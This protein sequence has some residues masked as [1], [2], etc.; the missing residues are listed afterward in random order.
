MRLAGDSFDIYGTTSD[1]AL[2]YASASNYSLS[3]SG[4]PFNVGQILVCSASTNLQGIWETATNETTVYLSIRLKWASGSSDATKNLAVTLQD[5]SNN[6]VTVMWL[7][8]GSIS[9]RS[10]GITGTLLGASPYS[11]QFLLNTWDSWQIAFVINSS[12]GSVEVRKDGSNSD[13]FAAITN[14]NTQ[15]GSGNSTVSG[16]T[17]TAN[18][19]NWQIDDLWFNSASGA[20]PTSWPGD[21]RFK[22]MVVSSGTQSQF[23]PSPTQFRFGETTTSNT[24]SISLNTLVTTQAF[25]ANASGTVSNIVLSLNSG[26]TGNAVM[27]LYD[28]TGSGGSPGALLAS[29]NA[30]SNPV[31]GN[32]TFTF[33]SPPAVTYN[34]TYYLALLSDTNCVANAGTSSTCYSLSQS[35]SSGL[36]N[37]AGASSTSGNDI[38][39][40]ATIIPYNWFLVSDATEDGDATYVYSSTVGQQDIY[41]FTSGEL[42][43]TP[44]SILGANLYVFWKKSDSGTRT[45]TI[46]INANGSGD[47]AEISNV[48]PSLSYTYAQKWL[49]T[50]PTG[51]AWTVATLEGAKPSIKVAS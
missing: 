35:Y 37:P 47:T 46:G 41:G 48:G 29:T 16:F 31:S 33:S 19:S 36:P 11:S 51:A 18:S 3:S 30:I 7:G 25:T 44:A 12:T 1:V 13:A 20:S 45:G 38:A 23:T 50:D 9:V 43:V 24:R 28:N 42:G 4:T 15:A 32:N 26:Y 17:I 22:Q 2:R 39:A 10:G 34:S 5:G 27:G 8:N 40:T 49:P 6:Q 21:V 14:V